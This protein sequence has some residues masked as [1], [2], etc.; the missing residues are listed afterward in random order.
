[1]ISYSSTVLA[2]EGGIAVAKEED[3]D[4]YGSHRFISCLV[5]EE[6]ALAE[7]LCYHF[8]S[9][10]GLEDINAC[11]PGGA[12]RN[13]TLGL[14]KLMK[15]KV[16]IPSLASQKE[17]VELHR[18]TNSIKEYHK[19]TEQELNELLPSL[20][21]KAFKGE[22][23]SDEIAE[24]F[25]VAVELKASHLP[26]SSIPENKKGFA[27][28]VLGGKIVSL[29][30]EDENFTNIKFQKLQ[31]LAEHIIEVDLN[32]NYYR[33][34]AGPYDNKFMHTVFYKLQQNQWFENRNYKFYPLKKA[35][36]IERHYQNYFGNK[37]EKLNKIFGL[38]QNAS[39]KFCEA[40]ATI[41]AVWN[42][43]IIQKFP[44][45]KS[46]IKTD[47]FEWSGRKEIIFSEEEFEQALSWMAKHDITPVG[48]GYLIKEKK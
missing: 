2:W 14:D 3:N 16:P 27:K 37:E 25:S 4:R 28:Q 17:F 43:H 30:K 5:D 33:Q 18:K 45:D 20:L 41:Y 35:D 38:L 8:L 42:N 13:K 34:S 21:D 40:V 23:F 15:I 36:N 6:K 7:Y 46:K 9:P 19:Q 10:K 32:W 44:F 31:Y 11:S 22:L 47:F 26:I 1:M 12:G 39:E 29:F 24:S 48:F